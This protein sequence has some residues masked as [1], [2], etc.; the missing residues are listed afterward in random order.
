MQNGSDIPSGEKIA[1]QKKN[2]NAVDRRESRSGHHIRGSGPIEVVQTIDLMRK[3]LLGK[4]GR[5]VHHG[6][7]I[8]EQVVRQSRI[9]FERLSH[10]PRHFRA[11]KCRS[12]LRRIGT[13]GH[14]VPG[15]GS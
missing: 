5:G 10:C 6:L 7:L 1:G 13:A 15:T 4:R 2:R 11:R 8:A 14:R 12:S 9:L 3:V